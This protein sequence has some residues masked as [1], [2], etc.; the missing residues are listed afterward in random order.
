MSF[1][2][3][4]G[5][6]SRHTRDVIDEGDMNAEKKLS[7]L[8]SN[9]IDDTFVQLAIERAKRKGILLGP[10]TDIDAGLCNLSTLDIGRLGNYIYTYITSLLLSEE[11]NIQPCISEVS[12]MFLDVVIPFLCTLSSKEQMKRK[13]L[14]GLFEEVIVPA[15]KDEDYAKMQEEEVLKIHLYNHD[16]KRFTFR[17]TSKYMFISIPQPVNLVEEHRKTALSLL[18]INGRYSDEALQ[19]YNRQRQKYTGSPSGAAIFIG[20]HVRL[21]DKADWLK[22]VSAGGRMPLPEEILYSMGQAKNTVLRYYSVDPRA[23][24]VFLVASD[25]PRWCKKYLVEPSWNI[26]F[27]ADYFNYLK[28]GI[29][30]IFF[31]FTILAKSNHSVNNVP[32]T[33]S[34]WTNFLSGGQIFQ[35]FDYPMQNKRL[36]LAVQIARANSPRYSK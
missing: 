15:V 32:G 22:H 28:P 34:Y 10:N 9:D 33:F 13:Y 4:K 21:T 8:V 25:N 20:V 14:L 1:E 24:V 11:F 30:E 19:Y 36:E 29:S 3:D 12:F 31:D 2:A 17:N 35:A 23:T 18:R 16:I 27:T 26:E 7:S 6:Q 5:T